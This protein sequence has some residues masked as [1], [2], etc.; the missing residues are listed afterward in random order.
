MAKIG[1]VEKSQIFGRIFTPATL[2]KILN[3][4]ATRKSQTKF[5]ANCMKNGKVT[6]MTYEARGG[7]V[8]GERGGR[9]NISTLMQI[10]NLYATRGSQ[11]KLKGNCM[12][13][14]KIHFFTYECFI[15]NKQPV[16]SHNIHD[17]IQ[18]IQIGTNSV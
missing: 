4:Y 5:E 14:A 2:M 1:A 15:I 7:R 10:L 13:N 12:K 18:Q 9:K 8:G 16:F 17:N 6:V 11:T 3:L